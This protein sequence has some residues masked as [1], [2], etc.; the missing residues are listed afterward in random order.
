M[1]THS[2]KHIFKL[3]TSPPN[4]DFQGERGEGYETAWL[5]AKMTSKKYFCTVGNMVW[6]I[7]VEPRIKTEFDMIW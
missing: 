4:K 5:G 7:T 6:N 2:D 1:P 3:W